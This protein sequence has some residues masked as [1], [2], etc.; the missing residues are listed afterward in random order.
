M[1]RWAG[2]SEKKDTHPYVFG[3]VHCHIKFMLVSF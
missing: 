2:M 3:H 1:C